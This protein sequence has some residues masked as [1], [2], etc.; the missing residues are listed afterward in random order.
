MFAIIAVSDQA[1]LAAAIQEKFPQDHLLLVPGQWLVASDLT[2]Q[3]LS[4]VLGITD[5][6]NGTAL[7]LSF[8]TY[9]GRSVPQTWE[10][11]A[12]KMGAKRA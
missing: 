5:G 6:D 8:Q 4:S 10:W 12:N 2:A 9:F 1:K 3:E 11:I 7:V